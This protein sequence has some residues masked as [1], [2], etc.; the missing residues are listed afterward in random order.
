[1]TAFFLDDNATAVKDRLTLDL[2]PFTPVPV[3][4]RADLK[5]KAAFQLAFMAADVARGHLNLPVMTDRDIARWFGISATYVYAALK[6]TAGEREAVLRGERPLVLPDLDRDRVG[7]L[8]DQAAGAQAQPANGNG[9]AAAN[10]HAAGNGHVNDNVA[11]S[12][13]VATG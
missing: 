8:L 3:I 2:L 4:R 12:G 6:C 13:I 5:G 9:R 7:A 10:G 11:Y 1:M